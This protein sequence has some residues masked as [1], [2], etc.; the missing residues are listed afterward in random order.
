MVDSKMR[1]ILNIENIRAESR[2]AIQAIFSALKIAEQNGHRPSPS[3]FTKYIQPAK[4][5]FSYFQEKFSGLNGILGFWASIFV[6]VFVL[7][8]IQTGIFNF[9]ID[10]LSERQNLAFNYFINTLFLMGIVALIHYLLD[11]MRSETNY[12]KSLLGH[13]SLGDYKYVEYVRQLLFD[14]IDTGNKPKKEIYFWK[15]AIGFVVVISILMAIGAYVK[16]V[17]YVGAFLIFLFW[18]MSFNWKIERKG[19]DDE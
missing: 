7:A 11:L 6:T 18:F 14:G 17:G 16:W 4:N 12:I 8:A 3:E 13:L 2:Q 19:E 15:M 10:F 9:H 5:Y 1:D